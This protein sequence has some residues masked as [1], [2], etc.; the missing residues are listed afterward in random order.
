MRIIWRQDAKTMGAILLAV[1]SYNVKYYG[2][3]ISNRL[4]VGIMLQT[5]KE[6]R[7]ETE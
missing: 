5:A 2:I 6:K 7:D 1:Q 4:F 3:M